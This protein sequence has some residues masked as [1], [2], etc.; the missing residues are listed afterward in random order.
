M[1]LDY[2][3]ESEEG[4]PLTEEEYMEI[5][6]GN[7]RPN[8]K[9]YNLRANGKS[10]VYYD[11]NFAEGRRKTMAIHEHQRWNSFMISRGMIPATCE[12]ILNETQ[13]NDEGETVHTNGKNYR[14]RRHGNLT[15]FEGLVQ[16]RRLVAT[17]DKKSEEK[18]DVIKYDYQILDD[19][20]WL[21]ASNGYKIIRKR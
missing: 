1:G 20:Y 11:I 13:I 8:T 21:L 9:K 5:Y 16:F 14:L 3:L 18:K 2:C 17:R 19:A 15:T 4:T 10:V 12:Q 6:A 7:D